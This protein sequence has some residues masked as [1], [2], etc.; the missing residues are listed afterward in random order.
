M[1]EI[2]NEVFIFS[3]ENMLN[4]TRLYKF[5]QCLTFVHTKNKIKKGVKSTVIIAKGI[6]ILLFICFFF[7]TRMLKVAKIYHMPSAWP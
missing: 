5:V 6:T 7:L 3:E 1:K 2:V 4:A